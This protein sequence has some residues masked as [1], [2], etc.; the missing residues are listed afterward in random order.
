MHVQLAAKHE[1]A[2]ERHTLCPCPSC[3]LPPYA[4]RGRQVSHWGVL[5]R[6][7]GCDLQPGQLVTVELEL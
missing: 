5:S 4:C 7:A 6:L 3:R 1:P 2:S